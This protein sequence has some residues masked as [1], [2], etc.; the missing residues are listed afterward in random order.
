M[1]LWGTE[2]FTSNL[3]VPEKLRKAAYSDFIVT[4][5]VDAAVLGVEDAREKSKPV[6]PCTKRL[7]GPQRRMYPS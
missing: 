6:C 1:N 3:R 5:A 4:T 7:H 2:E